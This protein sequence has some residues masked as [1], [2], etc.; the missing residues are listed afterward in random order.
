M[1][2]LKWLSVAMS[3]SALSG[4]GA[5]KDCGGFWDKTFGLESCDYKR[6]LVEAT[7][8]QPRQTSVEA[9]FQDSV[10]SIPAADQA[11]WTPLDKLPADELGNEFI[12]AFQVTVDPHLTAG[13]IFIVNGIAYRATVIEDN[14]GT[15][16]VHT[17]QPDI[18]EVFKTLNLTGRIPMTGSDVS[19]PGGS[20]VAA[21]T[22]PAGGTTF[23]FD[24]FGQTLSIDSGESG[25]CSKLTAD[26]GKHNIEAA[27]LEKYGA[28]INFDCHGT[29][30]KVNTAG[31]K[32]YSGG[33]Y[34]NNHFTGTLDYKGELG[35]YGDITFNEYSPLSAEAA[36]NIS[37]SGYS[38]LKADVTANMDY[39]LH[40][41]RRVGSHK[42]NVTVP[43]PTP[44]GPV[45]V[46]VSFYFFADM[47]LDAGLAADAKLHLHH[48]GKVEWSAKDE[49][50]TTS[51][52]PLNDK[53][54]LLTGTAEGTASV[55]MRPAV[56]VGIA[57][58]IPAAMGIPVGGVAEFVAKG[59]VT[60]TP[61]GI[62]GEG[63]ASLK[64]SPMA[65]LD[66]ILTPQQVKK[67]GLGYN[68]TKSLYTKVFSPVYERNDTAKGGE[69]LLSPLPVATLIY[70]VR[71]G[72]SFGRLDGMS[73][74]SLKHIKRSGEDYGLSAFMS[75]PSSGGEIMSYHWE[76][77][78]TRRSDD[79]PLDSP[80]RFKVFDGL[81]LWLTASELRAGDYMTLT[82][83]EKKTIKLSETQSKTVETERTVSEDLNVNKP[84]QI[85]AF[86]A[87]DTKSQNL[88]LSIKGSS[89]DVAIEKY[90]WCFDAQNDVVYC[91]APSRGASIISSYLG[92]IGQILDVK[93][94]PFKDITFA[95]QPPSTGRAALK[96]PIKARVMVWDN[97]GDLSILDVSEG[98]L[99]GEA[100]VL[101]MKSTNSAKGT[102]EIPLGDGVTSK[103]IYNN[104]HVYFDGKECDIIPQA[105]WPTDA[106]FETKITAENC[107][108][109]NGGVYP[110]VVKKRDVQVWEGKVIV[111][112]VSGHQPAS[113]VKDQVTTFTLTGSGFTSTMAYT[114]TNCA[115]VTKLSQT[116]TKIEF[117]CKPTVAQTE[118]VI[119]KDKSGETGTVLYE[120][121][122]NVLRNDIV[123]NTATGLLNDTGMISCWNEDS[124]LGDCATTDLGLWAGLRQDGEV[125]RDALAVKGN[126]VKV[127]GGRAGFDFS[128]I[129]TNGKKLPADAT[130]W[131]CVLDNRTG[132]L[133]EVKSTDS[134]LRD[135]RKTYT[136]YNPD[137]STNGGYAGSE[138]GENDTQSF[139]QAVNT[140][141]LC[142]HDDWRL[143]NRFELVS[144]VDF[145]KP[146]G[147]NTIDDDYFPNTAGSGYWTSSPMAAPDDSS[148]YAA[149]PQIQ[150]W[151]IVF[152]MGV[153]YYY[154]KSEYYYVRLVRAGD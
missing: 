123:Q 19:T 63:C 114:V 21:A 101:T 2:G 77:F 66:F 113:V 149:H 64:I 12:T 142:G 129:D 98:V 93:T 95:P 73:P 44:V 107:P 6:S 18:S 5:F 137:A 22:D 4:C 74:I 34:D 144:L 150:A 81:Q 72:N 91:E 1:S 152:S 16:V 53:T 27:G 45:P 138:Q 49:E 79:F 92:A 154:P 7:D 85:S 88:I 148:Y 17:E 76:L 103:D 126:L 125:G 10:K 46:V 84:P 55:R 3:V 51:Q 37:V 87:F 118:H 124:V 132:L 117:S 48:L 89:D 59:N 50:F 135:W 24:R 29:G 136:W 25:G 69:C 109:G 14:A 108:L 23:T 80:E 75:Q 40:Q 120:G 146:D 11:S 70:G 139:I 96:H 106:L 65:G 122:V 39:Q 56:G 134:G 83:K 121:G 38:Y 153:T 99:F 30:F 68:Y 32:S 13:D 35:F 116:A 54:P 15:W 90:Q 31:G 71:D 115:D 151:N 119:L 43:V 128:K 41:V 67:N 47:L 141:T 100:G 140:Q 26:L 9:A 57:G 147:S 60:A 104:Y 33:T 143:P 111:N 102:V 58:A 112:P 28:T 52:V 127:G 97:E 145:S 130:E 82:V 131:S 42:V 86:L 36:K 105:W 94:V 61:D 62:S 78:H 8:D 133:W 110:L 20:V